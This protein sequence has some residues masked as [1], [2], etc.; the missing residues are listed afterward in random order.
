MPENKKQPVSELVIS[1]ERFKV[2]LYGQGG[3]LRLLG[4]FPEKIAQLLQENHPEFDGMATLVETEIHC[5]G[6]DQD[7]HHGTRF[8]GGNPGKR[9]VFED[10]REICKDGK[11]TVVLSYADPV[12]GLHV[13]SYY[14]LMSGVPVIRRWVSVKNT[15]EKAVGIEHVFSAVVNGIGIGGKLDWVD[16]MRLHLPYSSWCAEG[17]WKSGRLSEFGLHRVNYTGIAGTGCVSAFQTGSWSSVGALPMAV[18]EDEELNV[19]W[20]WQIEHN[21]SWYWE[22]G[23]SPKEGLYLSAGG[24]NEARNHWWKNLQ[25]GESFETVPVAIGVVEGKF[26]EAISALTA[27]RRSACLRPHANNRLLPVV[28]NDY[29][30]CLNADP[31]TG[32][33]LPLIKAAAELGCEYYVIDAGWYSNLGENWWPTVGSW[34][35]SPDRFPGGLQELIDDIRRRGM[36][37]GL[38]LEIEVVGVQGPL[39]GKP[40]SWFMMRHGKR[41]IDH[42]RFL[43]DFRNP[44]VRKYADQVFG[45]LVGDY[46][47]GY[48]K[49]DYNVTTGVGTET[50]SDSFG[51][52]LLQHNRAFLSWLDSVAGKYPDLV[53]ENCASGGM[54]MDYASL[55][56]CQLQGVSDQTYYKAVPSIVSGSMAACLPEQLAVWSYPLRGGD[57]E[58][59]IFNMVNSMLARVYLSGRIDELAPG[60]LAYIR[61]ALEVYRTYRRE[62]P[63]MEPFWPTGMITLSDKACWHSHGLRHMSES[64]A[65]LSVWRFGSQ[66]EP[67]EISVPLRFITGAK[68][69]VKQIYPLDRTCHS[70]FNSVSKHLNIKFDSPWT[71]RLFR[72]EY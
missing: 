21:G 56:R 5:T 69:V 39:K 58:E 62:I 17:Q 57:E 43:L 47:I 35:P 3:N 44:E 61:Q 22:I 23:N 13:E 20:F 30:H 15:G 42:G 68:T 7:E 71:A 70:N 14:A 37:P 19:S 28:F 31:S 45:R 65:L 12:L 55:S 52:G 48:I 34:Q 53:M 6:Q 18:L 32:K 51:D 66:G 29:M 36:I 2:L 67:A 27:Y 50:D 16:K 11:R 64:W 8:T 60:R 4:M 46:G 38:W 54:R 59:V 41:V 25:P 26:G 1:H 33:E 49:N 10:M 72:I 63:Q 40:D 9:L 24:P